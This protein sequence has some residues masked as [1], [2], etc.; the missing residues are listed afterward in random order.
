MS[1]IIRNIVL[2]TLVIGLIVGLV[3]VALP[4]Q[5]VFASGEDAASIPTDISSADPATTN[6]R[7]E[8]AFVREKSILARISEASNNFSLVTSDIQTFL[9]KAKSNGKDVSAIQT[10]FDAF[11]TAFQSGKTYY[12]QANTIL[13]SQAGFDNNG[14]VIDAQKARTTVKSLRDI[15]LQYNG[16]V[17]TS[18]Q[19]LRDAVRN[20]RLANPRKNAAPTP[21]TT[22]PQN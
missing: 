14:K 11:K 3:V 2:S 13:T 4:F 7:L 5:S 9:D 18:R 8:L 6:S 15:L 19:A 1:T 20:F 21:T 16:T 12:D 22:N 10:A 17:K